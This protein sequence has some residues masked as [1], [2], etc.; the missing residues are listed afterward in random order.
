MLRISSTILL[1]GFCPSAAP[2]KWIIEMTAENPVISPHHDG[3][4]GGTSPK[5]PLPLFE[6]STTRR[7][8]EGEFLLLMVTT[9]NGAKKSA[10]DST[11]LSLS[12]HIYD[13]LQQGKTTLHQ[14]SG[15]VKVEQCPVDP[16]YLLYIR[17]F[18]T[19]FFMIGHYKGPYRPISIS[20]N[21]IH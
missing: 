19:Q 1:A 13:I 9:Q 17:D 6:K 11:N 21:V 12:W 20:W 3:S 4:G 14:A 5:K 7:E 2:E 16:G 18:S 8:N 10:K 15:L